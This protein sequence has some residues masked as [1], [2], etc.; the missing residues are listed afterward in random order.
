MLT[1]QVHQR[2]AQAEDAHE[3]WAV[4]PHDG[5]EIDISSQWFLCLSSG[6]ARRPRAEGQQLFP[7]HVNASHRDFVSHKRRRMTQIQEDNRLI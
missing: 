7:Q 4:A 5:D 3:L 6:C 2:L 1:V